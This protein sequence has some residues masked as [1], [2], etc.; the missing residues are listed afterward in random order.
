MTGEPK[1][2]PIH[3]SDMVPAPAAA[4]TAAFAGVLAGI[5]LFALCTSYAS[6]WTASIRPAPPVLVAPAA[7]LPFPAAPP[8][9]PAPAA[10][11]KLKLL[12]W[13][14]LRT[15]A[16]VERS[17]VSETWARQCDAMMFIAE[18]GN[19]SL[20]VLAHHYSKTETLDLWNQIHRAW[21]IVYQSEH[22]ASGQ[23]D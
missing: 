17:M 9:A 21:A 8:I 22:F 7:P 5:A 4:S 18:Q 20:G 6:D 16:D 14:P 2:P 12:C 3:C 23:F 11:A 19:A 1:N 13:V 15:P 10:R